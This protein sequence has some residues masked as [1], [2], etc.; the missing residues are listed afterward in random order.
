MLLTASELTEI[1]PR[2]EPIVHQQ[3][4]IHI[5]DIFSEGLFHMNH[6]GM[7]TFYNP[8]FYHQFGFTTASIDF[9]DW[10]AVVHPDDR[11]L[12][13]NKVDQHLEHESRAETE[14]RAKTISGHY[15]WLLG[16][17]VTKSEQGQ[18]FMVGSHRDI[19]EQKKMSSFLKQAAFY[20]VV[21]G[22]PN[23]TKLLRDIEQLTNN[24]ETAS[25][26]YIQIED[27]RSYVNQYSVNVIQHIL[28]HIQHAFRSV[29]AQHSTLYRVRSDD[30]AILLSGA[31]SIESLEHL[32]QS[33]IN[34]YSLSAQ[35]QGH[36]LGDKLNV[37]VLPVLSPQ[38]SALQSLNIAAQT[39]QYAGEKSQSRVEIYATET[40]LAVERYFFI[41]RGLKAALRNHSLSVKFQPIHE[42]KTGRVASF[43]ALVRWR[44]SEFG[45]IY[46][47][48]FIPVAEKKGL[49]TELGYQVFEKACQFIHDYHRMHGDTTRVNVNVSVLQLLNSNFPANLKMMT[50]ALGV[51]PSSIVLE[52][53][54]TVILDGNRHALTQLN[55]LS[56][57]GFKLS[58][59]DFG[60]GL[61]SI[62]SFFDL[63]LNQIKIDRALALKTLT[64][65]SS[66]QFLAF[67]VKLCRSRNMDVVIE[68]IETSA[69]Q[70]K[71]CQMG[72]NY[73]QGYWFAK[74]LSLATASR[75]TLCNPHRT[76]E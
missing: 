3:R 8:T 19:S 14:Y 73:L 60:A 5:F 1:H 16:T 26:I 21:S 46:P 22:M 28:Q 54:E 40:K 75:Y 13:E 24:N 37:G 68:G 36:L 10:L 45:E 35:E 33:L 38:L 58:L 65:A 27:I 32:C 49:I 29:I 56:R 15:I 63:P 64:N 12:L 17:A 52:L 34:H 69:M 18:R 25:L 76:C 6:N 59:D 55:T 31:N 44:S 4:L 9:N 71:F 70:R 62:Y 23:T 47:D 39:C 41:E 72:V 51:C 20:D 2:L 30:F 11:Q 74:P 66:E 57:M 43:E 42:A 67:I 48:E 7:M 61:S 50:N 53:T